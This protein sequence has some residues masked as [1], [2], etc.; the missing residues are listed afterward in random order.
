LE[1]LAPQETKEKHKVMIGSTVRIKEQSKTG[2]VT[3]VN[4]R[5]NTITVLVDNIKLEVPV[6][7]VEHAPEPAK[8][9]IL[10]SEPIKY[11]S[12]EL[13]IRGFRADD[14]LDI[15][16]KYLSDAITAGLTTVRIIHGKGTGALRKSIQNF[17]KHDPRV[18]SYRLGGWGEGDTGVTIVE[19]K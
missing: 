2:I 3:A 8:P 17:L 6:D 19:L 13:D 18:K 12:Y 7:T 1:T 15:T 4:T 10:H 14:A 5:R 9:V 11:V 16:D